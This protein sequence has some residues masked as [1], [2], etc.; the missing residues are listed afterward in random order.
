MSDIKK[1]DFDFIVP[2]AI[3]A[4]F[5]TAT[6]AELTDAAAHV[7][8]RCVGVSQAA[9]GRGLGGIITIGTITV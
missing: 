1:G 4:P 7:T 5:D 3:G 8:N 6:W 2:E 9:V